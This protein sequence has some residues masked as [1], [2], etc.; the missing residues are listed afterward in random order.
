[1]VF[2]LFSITKSYLN[3]T[4]INKAS[5]F[6]KEDKKTIKK[7]INSAIV[8]FFAK[9]ID[10][11][12][13]K[14]ELNKIH[15]IIISSNFNNIKYVN[16]QDVFGGENSLLINESNSILSN[17]FTDNELQDIS[18][19]VAKYYNARK[20]SV[21]TIFKMIVPVA[22]GSINHVYFNEK[23]DLSGFSELLNQQKKYLTNQGISS[24]LLN[25]LITNH[26]LASLKSSISIEKR[27]YKNHRK[28]NTYSFMYATI[29]G[30][31]I[32]G[33]IF[34]YK[35]FQKNIISKKNTDS[36]CIIK[37]INSLYSPTKSTI[38]CYIKDY[39]FLGYFVEHE[40][41]DKTKILILSNGGEARI[42]NFI[43]S[44]KPITTHYWFPF[45]RIVAGEGAHI[46]SKKSN[47]QIA[48]LIS[49]LKAYPRV[50]IKIAG[51][52]YVIKDTAKNFKASVKFAETVTNELVKG[53]INKD[54]II[55]EGYGREYPLN[56]GTN[57]DKRIDIR[58]TK[59]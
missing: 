40:L 27:Q 52:S 7:I 17:L 26:K 48:N 4:L 19:S 33:T 43:K 16:L 6:L 41:I 23:L 30:C 8:I 32:L 34:L 49:I 20:S 5:S 1:M 42:I 31:L 45:R 13:S 36:T 28:I 11:T 51:Y 29:V 10:K 9:T 3:N 21:L 58:I 37:D 59:K 35:T 53:G 46:L 22:I 12:N 56:I 44:K 24:S 15:R 18:L 39:E 38:N 2:G 14:E 50:H 55:Y 47:T 57:L 54:R 25:E